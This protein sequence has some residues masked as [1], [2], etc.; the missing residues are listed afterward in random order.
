MHKVRQAIR[1]HRK[2]LSACAM[3]LAIALMFWAVNS[4][5][6][7][8]VSAAKRVLP[9][10]SVQRDDRVV[11]LTFDAAWGNEDTQT[12]ID[13]L[14]KY[15]VHATFFVVGENVERYP[16]VVGRVIADGHELGNHTFSHANLSKLSYRKECEEI[17]SA[18]NAV[19]EENEYRTRLLRPPGGLYNDS[20]FRI[21]DRLDYT[22]ILWTID[23]RD[24]AHN[25]VENI[26]KEVL[27]KAKSGDII[28]FHDYIAKKSP[29][30]ESLEKIIPELKRRGFSFV[31][32]SEL[33]GIS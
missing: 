23:T 6:I 5:A 29:T 15:N 31:T 32:V 26:T 9:I 21:A 25:K 19:F 10:Y 1:K 28:L 17:M 2:L 30:P 7:V 16:D 14:G 33:L 18:E 11:S 27:G 8:G 4:P 12:L 24:W 13:I 3:V 20:I 22:V